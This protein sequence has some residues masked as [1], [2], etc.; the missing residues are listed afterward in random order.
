MSCGKSEGG[1]VE[2]EGG[3]L[4]GRDGIGKVGMGW[5]MGD[6]G[7]YSVTFFRGMGVTLRSWY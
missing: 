7:C 1:F 6:D 3:G 5:E 2:G 4:K